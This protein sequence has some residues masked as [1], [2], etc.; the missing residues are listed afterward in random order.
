MDPINESYNEL[1]E[2]LRTFN[3]KFEI[4]KFVNEF[5]LQAAKHNRDGMKNFLSRY[6]V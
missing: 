5:L 1:I 2:G 6:N 4:E 3:E